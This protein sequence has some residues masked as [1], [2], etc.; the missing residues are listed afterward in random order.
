M[1]AEVVDDPRLFEPRNHC[2]LQVVCDET[3]RLD[4]EALSGCIKVVQS[5]GYDPVENDKHRVHSMSWS[6]GPNHSSC[7][8]NP[9]SQESAPGPSD[10]HRSVGASIRRAKLRVERLKEYR[11]TNPG[12]VFRSSSRFCFLTRLI[13]F[14]FTND[15]GQ[16]SIV[17]LFG[18]SYARHQLGHRSSFP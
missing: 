10:P 7:F 16:E 9:T 17:G 15:L 3:K 2:N 18:R 4:R 8:K 12:G 1:L 13:F 14:L 5:R 11:I 6:S